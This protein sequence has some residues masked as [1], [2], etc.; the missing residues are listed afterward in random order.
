MNNA[1]TTESPS[2]YSDLDKMTT[3]E[4]LCS[5]N[6]EDRTVPEIVS[7]AIPQITKLV[8]AI[9]VRMRQGGRVFYIGSG[10]SGRLAI[11][12]ASE[13]LPTYGVDNKF[14]GLI[15]GGD[16][17][18]R[19]PIERAED[20]LNQG[21]ND[22]MAHGIASGDC[23]IALTASGKTPYCIGAV[24]AAREQGILTGCICCNVNTPLGAEV[25]IPVEVETGPEFVTGSTRMKA[26]TAEKLI[27]NMISTSL[28]V[29]LG[30]V[31]GNRMVDMQLTNSK[32][33]DR[34]TRMVMAETGIK[35]YD[36]AKELLLSYK[37]VRAAVD[38]W[39]HRH[40]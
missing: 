32:L 38:A 18:I 8:E 19:K 1:N 28:M 26:G 11:V 14:I 12:D 2:H 10:T 37:N 34:G 33:V 7:H 25:D 39:Q 23:L 4:I 22:L 5:I 27:L 40:D 15:S 29:R 9:L 17:A 16:T 6:K 21:W 31:R 13:I 30:H 3:E 20:D 24:R 36:E 35:D